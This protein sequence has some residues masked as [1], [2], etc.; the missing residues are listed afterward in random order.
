[1]QGGLQSMEEALF[2]HI[3]VVAIPIF[4]DQF[5]NAGR[6]QSKGFGIVLDQ[7]NLDV[8]VFKRT[9]LDVIQNPK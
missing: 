5:N 3:P 9:I 1:M 6:M 7:H 2:N 8:N 4:G